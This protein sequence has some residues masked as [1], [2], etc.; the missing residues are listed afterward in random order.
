LAYNWSIAHIFGV[1]AIL[2]YYILP[3]FKNMMSSSWC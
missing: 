2:A 3:D 1:N